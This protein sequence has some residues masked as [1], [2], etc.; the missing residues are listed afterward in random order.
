MRE[1]SVNCS[2]V[3]IFGDL[4]SRTKHLQDYVTPDNEVFENINMQD[5]FDKL[6]SE[7]SCFEKNSNFR[8][9]RQN[10]DTGVNNYGYRLIDFC[11]DN[12][13]LIING[14]GNSNSSNVTCKNVSTVDYFLS[15]PSV[16]ST[17]EDLYVHEFC[18][19][20]SD[21]HNPVSLD[22]KL[23]HF[24]KSYDSNTSTTDQTKLWDNENIHKY[25]S[26]FNAD[27]II[28]LCMHLDYLKSQSSAS[29]EDINQLSVS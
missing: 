1:W 2:S 22:V 5:L 26:K 11:I 29:Q 20:F 9:H 8:L 17:L 27:D 10:S 28:S 3:L 6:Q 12:D 7:L 18:E 25:V 24:N 16:F 14:R 23:G 19:L 21:S 15:C 13:L 4:N